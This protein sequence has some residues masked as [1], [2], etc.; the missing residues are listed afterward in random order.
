MVQPATVPSTRSAEA[1]RLTSGS[2]RRRSFPSNKVRGVIGPRPGVGAHPRPRRRQRVCHE[3][4]LHGA[5]TGPTTAASRGVRY[6]SRYRLRSFPA[7]IPTPNQGRP[8]AVVGFAGA[9]CAAAGDRWT[10]VDEHPVDGRR[11]GGSRFGRER[12]GLEALRA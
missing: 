2:R 3:S 6:A 11:Q 5:L 4:A 8:A 9:A 1:L 12:C 10:V 7:I